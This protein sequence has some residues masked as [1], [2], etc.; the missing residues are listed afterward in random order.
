MTKAREQLVGSHREPVQGSTRLGPCDPG[1][2]LHVVV[3][4]RRRA[5]QALDQTVQKIAHGEAQ[6]PLT[7]EAFAERFGA[8]AD[9]LA[10]VEAFA[11]EYGLRVAA[12]DAAAGAV[13]LGGTVERFQ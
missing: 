9:D 3:T 10:K 1:Q 13:T 8:A 4:V 6:Q 7:R 11:N 2:T 5:E 12:R